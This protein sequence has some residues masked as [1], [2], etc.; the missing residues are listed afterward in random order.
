MLDGVV[1]DDTQLFNDKLQEW[2]NFYNSNRPNGGLNGQT[3]YERL[4]QKT[5]TPAA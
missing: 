1:I 4:R 3:P 5:K 2:E